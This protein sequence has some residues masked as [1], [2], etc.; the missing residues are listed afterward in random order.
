MIVRPE[1]AVDVSRAVTTARELG[2]EIAVKG[3]G[4]SVAGHSS[5]DGG[6]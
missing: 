2:L 5:T 1:S 4:H 3:G 6:C